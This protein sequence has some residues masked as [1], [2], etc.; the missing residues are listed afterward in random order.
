VNP[1]NELLVKI[2]G[3]RAPGRALDLACGTG[4]NA[5]WLAEHGWMV[6][7]VDRSAEAI[8]ALHD[9]AKQ[10]GWR[11]LRVTSSRSNGNRGI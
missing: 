2:A 4:R 9:E 6:T 10:R 7:A 1:A 3:E 11:T 5:L 8:A